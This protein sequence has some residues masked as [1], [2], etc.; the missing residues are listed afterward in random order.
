MDSFKVDLNGWLLLTQHNSMTGQ[1]G[2][3]LTGMESQS[4]MSQTSVQH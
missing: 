2:M 1:A 3:W 4:M